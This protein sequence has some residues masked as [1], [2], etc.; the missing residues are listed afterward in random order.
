MLKSILMAAAKDGAAG[1]GA[2][3]EAKAAAEAAREVT[4]K[5]LCNCL[6]EDSVTYVKGSLFQTSLVRAQ[7]LGELVE[8]QP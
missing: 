1:G 7:A 5:V 8:V 6:S 3:A 2:A 4:V